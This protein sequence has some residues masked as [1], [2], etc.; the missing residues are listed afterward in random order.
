M[1]ADLNRRNA[2]AAE[3]H[4]KRLRKGAAAFALSGF[5]LALSLVLLSYAFSAEGVR[6]WAS[7]G[8]TAVGGLGAIAAALV[9]YTAIRAQQEVGEAALAAQSEAARAGYRQQREL[10]AEERTWQRL[11]DLL[12]RLVRAVSDPTRGRGDPSYDFDD[13]D[14]RDLLSAQASRQRE[15]L[16]SLLDE[17]QAFAPEGVYDAAEAH[18]SACEGL[19]QDTAHGQVLPRPELLEFEASRQRVVDTVRRATRAS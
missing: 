19:L 5:V 12:L 4:A 13:E 14:L 10:A 6:E 18:L 7:V 15:A 9:A 3:R 2:R 1:F 11:N 8:A 17:L 16:A